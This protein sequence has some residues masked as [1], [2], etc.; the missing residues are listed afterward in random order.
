MNAK[1]ES[2]RLMNELLR[3]AERMLKEHGEFYPYGGYIRADDCVVQV[4]PEDEDTDHPKSNDLLYILRQILA[5]KAEARE[6][7]AV[8]VVFDVLVNLPGTE[9]KTDAI[10]VN[11]EHSDGYCAEVF[12]PYELAADGRVIYGATFAQEGKP[13]IFG[14]A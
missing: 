5:A 2:E 6:C 14:K 10:Q 8:G 9:G 4:G 11:L 12:F 7:K 13:E 1:N 3:V